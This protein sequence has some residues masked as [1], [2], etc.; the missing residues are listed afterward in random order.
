M[1]LNVVVHGGACGGGGVAVRVPGRL[2][3][4]GGHAVILALLPVARG[5]HA[6]NN[7][8]RIKLAEVTVVPRGDG[9]VGLA[10]VG[11]NGVLVLHGFKTD[12]RVA[13]MRILQRQR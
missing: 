12:A 10:G 8:I 9:S 13:I 6:F 11:V 3:C 2:D 7:I 5:H 4:V 1:A